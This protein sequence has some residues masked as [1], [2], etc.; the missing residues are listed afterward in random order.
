MGTAEALVFL[1]WTI[2]SQNCQAD[3]YNNV[4]TQFVLLY[5]AYGIYKDAYVD[6]I[7]RS[8]AISPRDVEL[9]FSLNSF[10]EFDAVAGA[11]E[12]MGSLSMNW[13][14]EVATLQPVT[15]DPTIK[16][17]ILVDYRKLWTPVIVLVNSADSVKRIGDENYK[18]RF[19]TNTGA[20]TWAPRVIIRAA[21]TPD[22]TF[23]PFDKQTCV[24]TFTPWFTDSTQIR[25]TIRHDTWDTEEY[26]GNGVW[27]LDTTSAATRLS[28]NNYY[29]DF[30][31]TFVRQPI[32][33]TINIVLPV[34]LLSLLT[35]FVFLLP[36]A[37][38]ERVGF[39]ITC[40]LSFVVLLQTMMKFLP[41]ASA[42]MS[43]FCYYVI[44]MMLFS[45][46][47]SIVTIFLL[48]I[49]H[50]PDPSGVWR[51]LVHAIELITCVK[52]K[53]LKRSGFKCNCKRNTVE[54]VSASTSDSEI[55]IIKHEKV[56]GE[57]N[58]NMPLRASFNARRIS[59]VATQLK[60]A[61]E[62]K[63]PIKET[64]IKETSK[65]SEISE[66]EEENTITWEDVSKIL[67]FFFFLAFL[68]AQAAF[69]IFFL[70]PLGTRA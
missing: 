43:L 52:C 50:N 4:K 46:F 16:E 12:L 15:F 58:H 49:Y 41:E 48:R 59:D 66:E 38:G 63:P 64:P 70:V 35:G 69:S 65:I 30:T 19:N 68:G 67:D 21:C 6:T 14:D 32:Y 40:F 23:F 33:F 11:L 27:K 26:S 57:L 62:K 54:D 47:V 45:G 8:N 20:V 44:I 39:A 36:S 31:I 22:V 28:G 9:R 60:A 56:N 17:E 55:Q 42:P 51:W 7:P 53:R 10:A 24:L 3:T 29:A 61:D 2:L 37:S 34:L 25:L 5:D 18:V 1:C 13:T